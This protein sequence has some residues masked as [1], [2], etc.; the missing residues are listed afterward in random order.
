MRQ[1]YRVII[2]DDDPITRMDL[3]EMLQEQGYNVVAEGKNGKEAVR[4]TQMW[5]PHLIIMDVKM[6]I[7]DGL[8]ATGII[9]EHSDAAILLLTAY[10]QKDMVMQ[11]KAKGICAYLVKPVMEEELL[12]AVEF[13]L[14]SKQ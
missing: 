5:N 12:P 10:S 14:T 11:A 13:V 8:T 7:M 1:H 9:R 4:L 3:V 6:P 2:I